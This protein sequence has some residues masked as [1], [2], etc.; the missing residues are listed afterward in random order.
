[1]S[2]TIS[3]SE[4]GKYL[5]VQVNEPMTRKLAVQIGLEMN[6][7]GAEY[8]L[9]CYLYDMR[10]APNVELPSVNYFLAHKDMPTL[11]LDKSVRSAILVSPEDH[12]HDF[13]DCSIERGVHRAPVQG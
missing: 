13:G 11:Q 4:D 3:I 6:A 9:K 2:Y 10:E 8:G 5:R 7:T 1:M 12:S